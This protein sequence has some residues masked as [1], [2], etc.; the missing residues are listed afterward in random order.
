MPTAKKAPAKKAAAKKTA[1]K[2]KPPA[3][4]KRRGRTTTKAEHPTAA[5]VRKAI[6]AGVF[7]TDELWDIQVLAAQIMLDGGATSIWRIELPGLGLRFTEED[8]T[9]KEIR[10][11]TQATGVAL[12]QLTYE[13]LVT[14]GRLIYEICRAR[15][16]W[17]LGVAAADVDKRLDRIPFTM[18]MEG[19]KVEPVGDAPKAEAVEPLL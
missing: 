6:T 8:L 15:M 1:A 2:K 4:A 14:D 11:I 9:G 12:H 7:S 10:E 18:L 3:A 13:Y 5:K 19:L 16:L 17:T